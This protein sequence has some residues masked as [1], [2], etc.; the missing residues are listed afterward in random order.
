MDEDRPSIN[1]CQ[2]HREKVTCEPNEAKKTVRE[3]CNQNHINF[4]IHVTSGLEVT[5]QQFRES[6][7]HQQPH[8]TRVHREKT[9][10]HNER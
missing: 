9:L 4:R 8:Q 3:V 5:Q 2:E 1:G 6:P 10:I 7:G